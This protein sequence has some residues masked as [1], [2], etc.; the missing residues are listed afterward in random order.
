MRDDKSLG[1]DV[2][3]K[4]PNKYMAVIVSSKRAKALN[5]G[6]RPL[7]KIGQAKPTTIAME[8]IAAG[9]VVP[10]AEKPEVAAVEEEKKDLLPEPEGSTSA[11]AEPEETPEPAAETDQKDEGEDE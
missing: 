7:V 11:E 9:A 10:T 1:S 5:D 3:E 4:I 8:E 2:F 6:A